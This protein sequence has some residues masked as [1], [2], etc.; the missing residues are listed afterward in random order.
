LFVV[1]V[2]DKF[3][4][5]FDGQSSIWI[6]P[7]AEDVSVNFEYRLLNGMEKKHITE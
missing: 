6:Y 5:D 3:D 2:S 7:D 4:N 1:I